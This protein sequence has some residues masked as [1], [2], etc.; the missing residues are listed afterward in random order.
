MV[1]RIVFLEGA[2]AS[3][4]STVLDACC[5]LENTVVVRENLEAWRELGYPAAFYDDPVK[6]AWYF[7]SA[8]L[9]TQQRDLVRALQSNAKTVVVER[10]V[11]SNKMFADIL[12]ESKQISA[13]EYSIYKVQ[14]ASALESAKLLCQNVRERIHVFLDVSAEACMERLRNRNGSN[15]DGESAVSLDYMQK[16]YDKHISVFYNCINTLGPVICLKQPSVSYASATCVPN[17]A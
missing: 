2:I 1:Q 3:G 9:S 17:L 14:H 8:V 5:E 7:Q 12:Y 11:V 13:L 16:L 6:H 15:K 4:K 10:S